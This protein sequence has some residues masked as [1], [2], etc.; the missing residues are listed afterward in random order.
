M[1]IPPTFLASLLTC[2][3]PLG[4]KATVTQP[5]PTQLPQTSLTETY[6]RPVGRILGAALV[7]AEG[8][9]KLSYLSTH[10]GHRL[11]GSSGL[12]RAI[13]WIA[14]RM[15]K[16]GLETRLQKVMVPHWV[17]GLESARVVS[18]SPR[19]LPMLGLGGSIATPPDGITAPV[20]VVTSFDELD[21]LDRSQVEGRIVVFAVDWVGYGGTV[22]YRS[23]GAS[24]AAAKGA[25]AAFVRSAT[26][27][28]LRTPHTGSLRYDQEQPKIPA[29]AITPED[30]EWFRRCRADGTEVTAHLFMEAKTLPD[31]PSANIIAEI[32][33]REEPDKV[34]VM[35]GHI[36]SWD[37]GEGTQDDGAPSIAAWHA[38]TLLKD[39][40]LRPRRTL[41]V[42]LWTNEENGLRGATAYREALGASAE[43]HVAAIEMD[44]GC[45][46]PVGFG[47]SM[48]RPAV[49]EDGEK[50]FE[51]VSEDGDDER[52][53]RAHRILSEI[54]AFFKP[55]DASELRRGGG[56]ADIGPLMRSGVPGMHLNTVG[57]RYFD[58]HHTHAD[59]LDKVEPEDF[60]KAVALFAVM[61]Y[62]LADM[63]E[64]LSGE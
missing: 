32:P 25:V 8:W 29:A 20:V 48:R 46:R 21:A 50:V 16:E 64:T 10:I 36:D 26:G 39:L 41:R 11:S 58:W 37:V 22:Q 56:G 35:G 7:D 15:R 27:H 2:L 6:A 42:V 17:R 30:S 9:E 51:P 38:L 60:K 23:R 47:F 57:E 4:S 61:G 45:E 14:D 5:G 34:V 19:E 18:P 24:R 43:S 59:T 52:Y 31:A 13:N 33:G 28:S 3:T 62:V 44:G 1:H 53:E 49:G 54:S 40:G 12:E 63:P 55:L